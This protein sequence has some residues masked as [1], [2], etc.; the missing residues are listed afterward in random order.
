MKAITLTKRTTILLCLIYSAQV[1]TRDNLVEM[2]LK[3]MRSIHNKAKEELARLRQ[4]QQENID[5]LLGVFTNVL[6]IFV[7]E[8]VNTEVLGQVNQVFVPV[9]GAQQLLNECEA[10]NAYKGNNYLPLLWRFYK[11]HRCG[12]FRLLSALKFES[13]TNEQSV[14]DAVKFLLENS[15][16]RGEFIQDNI[17]IDFASPQWQKLVFTQQGEH[18]KIIRR[19][20]EVCVFSY[21]A[22]ELR[23]GDIC[24]H[25]SED[26]ADHREQLLPWSECLPLIDQYCQNLGL[27]STAVGFVQQLKSMLAETAQKVDDAYPDNRQVVI[28]D[29]GEPVLKKPPRHELSLQAKALREAVEERFSERNLIEILRNVDYWTNFTRHFGPLS[30]SDPKLERAIE[31]YLLTTFAYGCNLGPI[32]AARH[33]RG[34]VTARELSF[35]NRRHV[36]ADKLNAALTDIINRYNILNLPK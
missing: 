36:N 17:N 28:N 12:F 1:Q 29:S 21:L 4:K 8:P 11:S 15:H 33:M 7:D 10:V 27:A 3:K 24:V 19:H 26:Y 32:Q 2:F 5:K 16:R 30:G 35:V 23:S 20:L 9:G 18:S 6:E 25:G 13:T 31:R 14:V 22:A 34:V